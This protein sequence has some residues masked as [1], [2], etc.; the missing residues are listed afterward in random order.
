L[1]V[2]DLNVPDKDKSLTTLYQKDK[3]SALF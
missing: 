1:K 2:E 3:I